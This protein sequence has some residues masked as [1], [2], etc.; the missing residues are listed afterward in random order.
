MNEKNFSFIGICEN[1]YVSFTYDK[2]T[3]LKGYETN[4]NEEECRK[5]YIKNNIIMKIY[6]DVNEMKELS[7]KKKNKIKLETCM[8]INNI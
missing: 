1:M 4:M 3:I 8:I 2:E 6:N 7:D 5:E